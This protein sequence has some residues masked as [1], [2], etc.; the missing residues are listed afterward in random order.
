MMSRFHDMSY[1]EIAG[2]LGISVNTVKYHIKQSLVIMRREL[3]EY[4]VEK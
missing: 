3:Q 4:T 1:T 2:E